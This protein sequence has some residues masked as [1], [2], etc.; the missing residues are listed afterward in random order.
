MYMKIIR[1]NES[2]SGSRPH[3]VALS[4]L[5]LTV[6]D[7]DIILYKLSKYSHYLDN[8]GKDLIKDLESFKNSD[9]TKLRKWKIEN[10]LDRYKIQQ[11][12]IQQVDD[13]E[14]Y[15]TEVEDEGW[16]IKIDTIN[17]YITFSTKEHPIK[18]LS[19]LFH[20]LDNNHRLGFVL[21]GV[22]NSRGVWSVTVKYRIR[23]GLDDNKKEEDLDINRYHD[24]EVDDDFIGNDDYL[25]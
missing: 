22:D 19:I 13:I 15:L 3:E 10:I 12:L 20:F 14:D 1:F 21:Q 18:K 4:E 16:S 11:L 25:K 2:V 6:K 9:W 5:N 23:N 17:S 8:N 24:D 7:M